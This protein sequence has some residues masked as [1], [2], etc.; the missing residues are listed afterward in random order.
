MKTAC[1]SDVSDEK[2]FTTYKG[3]KIYFCEQE[4]L[5]EFLDD[6][7]EFL[8]SDHFLLE[9]EILEDMQ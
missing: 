3:K 4:C 5:D 2:I 7:E 6:P 1:N 9:F 8:R